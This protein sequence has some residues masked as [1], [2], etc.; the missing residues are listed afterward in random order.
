MQY[1]Y[2]SEMDLLRL[3]LENRLEELYSVV[4]CKSLVP[5]N[6]T[7]RRLFVRWT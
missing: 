3:P 7:R 6:S 4:Q 1:A 5:G 2:V